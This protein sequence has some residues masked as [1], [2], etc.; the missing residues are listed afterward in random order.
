MDCI[1]SNTMSDKQTV[2]KMPRKMN[3]LSSIK[4]KS[5]FKNP[6]TYYNKYSI[7]EQRLIHLKNK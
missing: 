7:K 6:L 3:L 1:G 4:L 5:I 2:T